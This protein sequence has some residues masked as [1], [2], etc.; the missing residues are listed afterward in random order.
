MI[1]KR[2]FSKS[3]A[4]EKGTL[5]Q[6]K[7]LIHRSGVPIDPGNNVKAAEDFLLVVLH[8]HIV[9]AA[10][11]ILSQSHTT[12]HDVAAVSRK[13]VEQYI[14][15]DVPSATEPVPVKC[16]DKVHLY[17]IELMSLGILWHNFHDSIKE[18]DDNRLIRNWKFNLLIFKAARRKY[19]ALRH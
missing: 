4:G 11:V 19:I 7:N 16:K 5:Y 17:A 18:G 8:S 13:I 2:L 1:W 14:A 12:D 10:K 3:S 9:A 6:L 15:I